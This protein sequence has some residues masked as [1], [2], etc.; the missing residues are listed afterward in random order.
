M[1]I[2]Y[3]NPMIANYE[4]NAPLACA[5]SIERL[6]EYL[7]S[8]LADTPYYDGQWLKVFKKDSPLEWYN[9]PDYR[10]CRNVG[11]ADDWAQQARLNYEE[12][13]SSL[14]KV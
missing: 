2:L 4:S 5:E 14:I 6:Q 8:Q 13:I 3:L 12:M 10:S 11:T 9:G 7:Q 1:Y